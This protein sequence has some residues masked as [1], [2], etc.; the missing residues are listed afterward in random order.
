M[1]PC[2]DALVGV[3]FEGDV[4]LDD[5]DEDDVDEDDVDEDDVD[6]DEGDGVEVRD[7]VDGLPPQPTNVAAAAAARINR[8]VF[9]EFSSFEI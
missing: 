9:T 7:K 6:E 5:V 8:R 2:A 1:L 3:E 4:E